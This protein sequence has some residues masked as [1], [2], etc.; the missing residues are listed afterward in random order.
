MPVSRTAMLIVMVFVTVADIKQINHYYP[1][2]LNMEGQLEW[3]TGSNKYQYNQKRCDMK[4]LYE[5]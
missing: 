1:F 2:G 3:C 5:L 4:L